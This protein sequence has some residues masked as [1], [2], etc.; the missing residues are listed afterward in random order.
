M[1]DPVLVRS[2]ADH[3]IQAFPLKEGY[4]GLTLADNPI[5]DVK[6]VRCAVGGSITLTYSSGGTETVSLFEGDVYA[7]PEVKSVSITSGTFHF[8]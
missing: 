6:M 5:T 3:Q 4:V 8:S 7:L 2:D 1:S